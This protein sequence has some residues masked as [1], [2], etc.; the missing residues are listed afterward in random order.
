MQSSRV[1]HGKCRATGAPSSCNSRPVP[2]GTQGRI[3]RFHERVEEIDG[4]PLQVIENTAAAGNV[5]LMHTLLLHAAA[6]AAHLGTQ[7]RFVLSKGFQ[8]RYW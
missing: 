1:S 7:P 6:P 4:L 8:E 3:A 5:I 2:N